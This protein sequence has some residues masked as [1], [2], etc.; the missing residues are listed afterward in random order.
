MA[1]A[2][3]VPALFPS[4]FGPP[5]AGP[6]GYLNSYHASQ[7]DRFGLLGVYSSQETA[8]AGRGDDLGKGAEMR[9][10][11]ETQGQRYAGCLWT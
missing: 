9:I 7:I 2:R 1:G 5:Q 4:F 6:V 10:Q 11:Q 8:C 3:G